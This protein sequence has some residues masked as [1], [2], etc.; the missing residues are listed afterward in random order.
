MKETRSPCQICGKTKHGAATCYTNIGLICSV[1]LQEF[2]RKISGG[3]VVVV[4]VNLIG[5]HL[6]HHFLLGD[7]SSSLQ[8]MLKDSILMHIWLPLL[9]LF[10]SPMNLFLHS[11]HLLHFHLFLIIHF[12]LNIHHLLSIHLLLEMLLQWFN[13]MQTLHHSPGT[14]TVRQPTMLQMILVA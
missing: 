1:R 11:F 2:I 12:I 7:N 6:L 4:N 13:V 9:H 5:D 8:I 3:L 10:S 14:L